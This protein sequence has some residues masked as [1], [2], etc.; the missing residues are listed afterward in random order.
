MGSPMANDYQ[1]E[2]F[3]DTL[4]AVEATFT[5]P[6][7]PGQP[8]PVD[9]AKTQLELFGT[10]LQLLAGLKDKCAALTCDDR[11]GY[12]RTRDMIGL[13]RTART[14]VEKRR[15]EHNEEAHRHIKWVNN[16][17]KELT[18]FIV[19]L[20]DPL[21]ELKAAVDEAKER[22]KR[23]AEQAEQERLA[24]IE[25]EKLAAVEA[26]RQAK[27]AAEQE[28]L[29]IEGERLQAERA[30]MEA[31]RRRM[32]DENR[33]RLAEQMA[34]R[35]RVTLERAAVEAEKQRLVRAESARLAKIEAERIAAEAAERERLA[36]A[37]RERLRVE[38]MPDAEA[39]R[40]FSVHVMA[41]LGI[42]PPVKTEPAKAVMNRVVADLELIADE[43]LAFNN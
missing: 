26:E 37:E 13:L 24:A 39:M 4:Q 30:A 40:E 18:N 5:M 29:R 36:A 43:L 41:L 28:R 6:P 2:S 14:R 27:H 1:E 23:E 32:D 31:E 15:K 11:Q 22:A 9:P 25:R 33:K 8:V 34:E 19:N 20:E 7:E 3:E 17:A 42:A 12:E 10:N 16:T 38:A 35:E 21:K